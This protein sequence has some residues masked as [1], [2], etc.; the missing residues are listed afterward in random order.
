MPKL[1]SVSKIN[2]L[3]RT[4]PADV[5]G[6]ALTQFDSHF[7]SI[8]AEILR[9]PT[10]SNEQWWQASLPVRFSGLGVNQ[11]KLVA[12]SAYIG[13][14]ALTKDLVAALLKRDPLSFEPTGWTTTRK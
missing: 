13:S 5:L 12:R 3:L 7:Q 1:S 6:E 2:H 4:C 11:T 9:V 14:C 10:L 8:V